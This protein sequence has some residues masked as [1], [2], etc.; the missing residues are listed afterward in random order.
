MNKPQL[1]GFYLFFFVVFLL[2]YW[3]LLR[4]VMTK[5]RCD[6]G[7]ANGDWKIMYIPEKIDT[8]KTKEENEQRIAQI[9]YQTCINGIQPEE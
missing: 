4:P 1:H 8:Q 7:L 2:S 6:I 9:W 5:K 3:F